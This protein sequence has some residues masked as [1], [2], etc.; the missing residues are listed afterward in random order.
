MARYSPTV[1]PTGISPLAAA[2]DSFTGNYRDSAARA[3]ERRRY[4]TERAAQEEERNYGR[5]RDTRA[6]AIQEALLARQGVRRGRAP[7][8]VQLDSRI[9]MAGETSGPGNLLGQRIGQFAQPKPRVLA[10]PGSLLPDG[11]FAQR[12]IIEQPQ[13]RL[14]APVAQYQG[15]PPRWEQLTDEFYGESEDYDKWEEKQEQSSNLARLMDV[16]A[17][18]RAGDQ[19]AINEL[20]FTAPGAHSS[21]REDATDQAAF[22][23][24]GFKGDY[25]PGYDY[26]SEVAAGHEAEIRDRFDARGDYRRAAIDRQAE[27]REIARKRRRT[28]AQQRASRMLATGAP[29]AQVAAAI[30]TYPEMRGELTFEDVAALEN[31]GSSSSADKDPAFEERRKAWSSQLGAPRTELEQAIID[32]LATGRTKQDILDELKKNNSPHVKAANT[33]L[34]RAR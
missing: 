4:E 16:A 14:E 7:D 29:A 33:Y 28:A 27:D 8:P 6:D 34:L 3:E 17:R 10:L 12:A 23:A 19:A 18:A 24:G 21:V 1:L 22:K 2:I 26:S 32:E 13:M 15:A 31:K 5:E 20:M 11:S 25:I 9:G 30:D